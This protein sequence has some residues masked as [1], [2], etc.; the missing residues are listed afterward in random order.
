MTASKFTAGSPEL[1]SQVTAS[2][3]RWSMVLLFSGITGRTTWRLALT[4]RN[5]VQAAT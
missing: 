1:S 2:C 5:G 4:C 3:V